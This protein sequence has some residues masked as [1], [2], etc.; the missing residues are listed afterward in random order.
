MALARKKTKK[1]R[2]LKTAA[3]RL[4]EDRELLAA[5]VEDPDAFL[6][7][8]R[9]HVRSIFAFFL[10]RLQRPDLAADLTGEVFARALEAARSEREVQTPKAWLYGIAHNT[11]AESFRE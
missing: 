7:F 2:Q 10:I 3:L 9:R 6:D 1:K 8:Y 11:L 5:C 4:T